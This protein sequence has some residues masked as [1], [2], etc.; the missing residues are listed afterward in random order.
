MALDFNATITEGIVSF[1]PLLFRQ[2]TA[3]HLLFAGLCAPALC[4]AQWTQAQREWALG[5]A[6]L[7]IQ[8]NNDRFDRL[9]G[10]D[11]IQAVAET[12]RKILERSWDITSRE[13]LLSEIHELLG[14]DS[15]SLLIGW[16]YPRAVN[17][18]RLGFAA[19]YLQENEAWKLIM[20]AAARLQQTFS[21]WQEL[22]QVYMDARV[23]FYSSRIGDR[24]EIEYAYRSMLTEPTT[25]WR[26]YP[27]NLDL[28]NGRPVPPSV[29][30]TGTLTI[31]AHPPRFDLRENL[32]P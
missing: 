18:A 2:M 10:A 27:W 23:Q 16:N 25:P 26:K 20:P 8:L 32:R 30:K 17:L 9:A 28:G 12:D 31:A 5:T 22:G 4:S 14:N 13:Q 11:T 19:G 1:S 15:S 6:G 24:R 21:S 7:L 3:I 29:E